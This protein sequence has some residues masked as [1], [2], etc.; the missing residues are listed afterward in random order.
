MVQGSGAPLPRIR[1]LFHDEQI[2][3]AVRSRAAAGT[4]AEQDELV[5]VDGP[6]QAGHDLMQRRVRFQQA[7][8]LVFLHPRTAC[9][10]NVSPFT[11]GL[12]VV[13]VVVG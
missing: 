3:I 8:V 13:A 10:P 11:A 1:F 12:P 9:E 7:N 2:V 6:H 5:G 4:T